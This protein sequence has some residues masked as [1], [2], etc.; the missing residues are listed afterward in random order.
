MTPLNTFAAAQV[1]GWNRALELL[2]AAAAQIRAACC[3]ADPG[4]VHDVLG[5]IANARSNAEH[6]RDR[7]IDAQELRPATPWSADPAE[8]FDQMVG[9]AQ[10]VLLK[11]AA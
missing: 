1:A 9:F 5:D 10:R 11:G 7:I 4:H 8:A 6:Y 2:D 3:N